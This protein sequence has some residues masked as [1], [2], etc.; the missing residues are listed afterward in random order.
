MLK[1]FTKL[2]FKNVEVLVS[3]YTGCPKF[4][5][6]LISLVLTIFEPLAG[7]SFRSLLKNTA[8]CPLCVNF[9]FSSLATRELQCS[10][11]K[12]KAKINKCLLL[13]TTSIAD[14]I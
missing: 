10:V 12:D 3:L 9:L 11:N 7:S 5:K 6:K 13:I 1:L 14:L 8:F 4:T 2:P